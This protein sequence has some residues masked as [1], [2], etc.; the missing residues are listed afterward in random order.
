MSPWQLSRQRH[1][2]LGTEFSEERTVNRTWIKVV[3]AVLVVL[4][5]IAA[6]L[7]LFI[8]AE[9]FRPEIE[10]RLGAALNR[11]VKLGKLSFSL[12]SGG[13]AAEDISISDDP[14]FSRSP[15]LQAKSL[16]VGVAL[17]P[18]ITSRA[19]QIESI[20]VVQPRVSLLQNSRGQ[21]NF[22]SIGGKPSPG[23]K[24]TAPPG[25][26]A[27]A[28]TAPLSIAKLQIK[29]GTIQMT[30]GGKT[31]TYTNVALTARDF[32]S[33]T[34][35]PFSLSAN[36]P[37]NGKLQVEG[38]GGPLAAD[39]SAT[40]FHANVKISGLDVGTY[41]GAASGISGLADL[42]AK[43]SSL[44]GVARA[45]GNLKASKLRLARA[46]TP[47]REPVTLDF[48]ADYDLPHSQVRINRGD[49]HLGGSVA[50]ITGNVDQRGATPVLNL[51]LNEPG[52]AAADLEKLLPP[53]AV[54]L[55]AGVSLRSGTLATNL[56]VEGPTDRLLI[57]GPVHATNVRLSGFDL[58]GKFSAI[59]PLAGIRTGPNTDIQLLDAMLR[60]SPEGTRLDGINT[61]V[62]G[63]GSMVGQGVLSPNGAL[64]F[65]L[66]AKLA[67]AGG[68]MAGVAQAAGLGVNLRNAIPVHVTGTTS[69]PKFAADMSNIL[70]TKTP[71][72]TQ[73]PTQQLNNPAGAVG[74]LLQG[75]F[76][77][78][79]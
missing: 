17:W 32:S 70:A 64:D 42:D 13:I 59:G 71:S 52:L 54:S 24:P 74:G 62:S 48:G 57:T 56:K 33:T 53:A 1:A 75:L 22:S 30:S 67:N 14:A 15:F 11:T 58:G 79:K 68:L 25:K 44:N 51:T 18:L 6:A 38:Q 76:G 26:A 73:Q 47:A 40:P 36:L 31:Q 12:L 41:M 43:V 9:R 50:H 60:I 39:A 72:T 8:N 21:W 19:V 34:A 65:H 63:V 5:L 35:S 28:Q 29:D 2:L 3:L 27:S 7:P 20:T 16:D 45:D 77:K 61:I 55:P 69:N 10:T 23:E 37:G 4:V 66:A 49:L 78:K 46:G